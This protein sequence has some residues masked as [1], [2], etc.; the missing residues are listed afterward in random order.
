VLD[1]EISDAEIALVGRIYPLRQ[2][3]PSKPPGYEDH[4]RFHPTPWP[5][6]CRYRSWAKVDGVTM[7]QTARE[8]GEIPASGYGIAVH[9]GVTRKGRIL[10]LNPIDWNLPHGNG[11][12]G[13]TIGIEIATRRLCGSGQRTGSTLPPRCA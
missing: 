2:A 10:H 9:F 7:H 8:K 3:A 4:T 6:H 11:L 13:R 1:R 5:E 12:N